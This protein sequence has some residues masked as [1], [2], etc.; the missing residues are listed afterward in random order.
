M[1]DAGYVPYMKF[2]LHD[3]EEKKKK[4]RC[5]VCVTIAKL[6]IALGVINTAPC[7]PLRIMKTLQVCED[8]HTSTK[9]I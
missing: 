2:V 1:H 8:C 5:F 3:V 4:K 6:A 9:F 7:A